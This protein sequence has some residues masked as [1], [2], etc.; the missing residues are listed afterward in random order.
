[1]QSKQQIEIFTSLVRVG[2]ALGRLNLAC[3]RLQSAHPACQTGPAWHHAFESP[4][5]LL[6]HVLVRCACLSRLPVIIIFT[7]GGRG[8]SKEGMGP[9]NV[10]QHACQSTV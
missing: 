7:R 4:M 10:E 2:S 9:G 1:M 3:L 6:H 8:G 5:H